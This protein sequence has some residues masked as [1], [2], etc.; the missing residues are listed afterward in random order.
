L[1]NVGCVLSRETKFEFQQALRR[2]D[3]NLIDVRN[4]V[5]ES[6]ILQP[7]ISPEA[8]SHTDRICRDRDKAEQEPDQRDDDPEGR[9]H[10]ENELH[11]F[12]IETRR[13]RIP[14]QRHMRIL[15][16]PAYHGTQ[17]GDEFAGIPSDSVTI[18]WC[19]KTDRIMVNL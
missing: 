19:F 3:S 9:D 18:S 12:K 7:G 14:R 6:G 17:G 5:G 11:R 13:E 4:G 15:L 10:S 1:I 2:D 16:M 8:Q